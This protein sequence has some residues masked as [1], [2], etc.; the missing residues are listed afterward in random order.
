MRIGVLTA[1]GDCPG[2]NAVIRSV[3]HRAVTAYGDEVIGFEDGYAGLLDGRYRI[4][5][6]VA[7]GGMASVYEATDTRLDRTVAVKV[8]HP[9]LGDGQEFAQRSEFNE[10]VSLEWWVSDL[11]GHQG[12]QRLIKDLNGIYR[13]HP[14][15]WKLDNDPR[16]F[17]WINADDAGRNCYSWIRQDGDGQYIAVVVNFSSEP[18]WDY[19]VGLP[20]DGRW[21][22]IFNSDSATYDGSGVG[23]F[24][25]V[26]ATPGHWD[27]F[28]ARAKV[29][30]PPLAAVF[31]RYDG[32]EADGEE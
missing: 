15:F 29:Q 4:L 12:V 14:A 9:G 1:G 27:G 25:D 5:A 17:Q 13:D 2:L 24:G 11:W 8:M 26:Q 3:V 18:G 19:E 6:R 16:G 22:E 32:G 7:R 23:N 31:L 20:E 10:A 30:V 28:A 21:T